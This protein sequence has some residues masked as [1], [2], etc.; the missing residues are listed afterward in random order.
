MSFGKSRARLL[1]VDEIEVGIA[2]VR[3]DHVWYVSE[4]VSSLTLDRFRV[5]LQ[6]A[7]GK[8]TTRLNPTPGVH[9][10]Y[11]PAAVGCP[12]QQQAIKAVEPAYMEDDAFAWT[13]KCLS[14]DND[15]KMVERLPGLKAA[16]EAV[17]K[18]LKERAIAAGGIRL[19]NGKTWKQKVR[20]M[21]RF[22]RAKAEELLGPERAAECVERREELYFTQ[23][24]DK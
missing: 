15:A 2:Y 3:D 20:V 22:L 16:I 4:K 18:A 23:V 7:M 6:Q 14:V 11:C 8:H 24:K 17:E 19:G 9:C 12:A 10:R 5:A 1:G 21:P 13:T